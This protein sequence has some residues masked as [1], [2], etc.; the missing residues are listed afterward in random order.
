[1]ST[2]VSVGIFSSSTSSGG[3]ND[4]SGQKAGLLDGEDALDVTLDHRAYS[5]ILIRQEIR[6]YDLILHSYM[7]VHRYAMCIGF[8]LNVMRRILR[9]LCNFGKSQQLQRT[10]S[11]TLLVDYSIKHPHV[12]V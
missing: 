7:Y 1:M 11:I 5:C 4:P 12:H 8:L 9:G 10:S 2:T 3:M 6:Y